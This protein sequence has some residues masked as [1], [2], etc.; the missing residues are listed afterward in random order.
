[1]IEG[2]DSVSLIYDA[3]RDNDVQKLYE[4][5]RHIIHNRVIDVVNKEI[6]KINSEVEDIVHRAVSDILQGSTVTKSYD[7]VKD[8]INIEVHLKK[9]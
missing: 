3:C 9:V 7:L 5:V 8:K 2:T 6:D 1:M 4:N